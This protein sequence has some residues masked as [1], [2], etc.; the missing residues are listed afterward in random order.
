[1]NSSVF[2]AGQMT[3]LPLLARGSGLGLSSWSARWRGPCGGPDH[4]AGW[5]QARDSWLALGPVRG[6]RLAGPA[7][8]FVT[9]GRRPL[10]PSAAPA[11]WL[12]GLAR[13]LPLQ[14]ALT[15]KRLPAWAVRQL[16]TQHLEGQRGTKGRPQRKETN[17]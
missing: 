5:Q 15:G 10:C 6:A 9:S 11:L 7:W 8:V 17:P 12:I 1:M 2:Q 4:G 13:L 16:S 14:K 3:R